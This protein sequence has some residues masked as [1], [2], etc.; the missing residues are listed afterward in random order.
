MTNIVSIDEFK[1]AKAETF[2]TGTSAPTKLLHVSVN[3]EKL[4]ASRKFGLIV[5]SDAS[6]EDVEISIV[7]AIIR[8]AGIE[9]AV[10]QI[11]DKV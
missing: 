7:K 6:V 1:A 2:T 11:E 10:T 5:P 9:W 4:Q 8:D 3:F